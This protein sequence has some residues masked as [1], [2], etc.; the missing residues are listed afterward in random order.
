MAKEIPLHV[1]F[2]EAWIK[3]D[4]K[5]LLAKRSSQ[6]DQAWGT[7][8]VPWGKIEIWAGSE[9]NIIEN[10]LKREVLE[11]VWIEIFDTLRYLHSWSFFRSSWHHVIGIS[12]LAT[13][14]S[15]EAKPLEDQEEVKWV[16]L[17]EMKVLL[18]EPHRKATIDKIEQEEKKN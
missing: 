2:T 11:E 5:Y 13:Y 14:A 17:E 3:K 12:F 18:S 7:R 10:T 16:T 9:N 15:W 6:D 8:A 1:V 4:D